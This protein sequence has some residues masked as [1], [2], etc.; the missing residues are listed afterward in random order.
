MA[1]ECT[2]TE[3]STTD[4]PF[5]L[6]SGA[7]GAGKRRQLVA[8]RATAAAATDTITLAT[9]LPGVADVEGIAWNTIQNAVSV[10]AVTWS[11]TT[12]TAANMVAG[13]T[14]LELGVIVNFS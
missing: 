4:L 10:T 6:M 7:A 3:I 14:L 1:A 9:Y 12:V 2:I 11:T 5:N 8:I 13:K